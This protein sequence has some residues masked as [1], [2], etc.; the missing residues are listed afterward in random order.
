MFTLPSKLLYLVTF[1][2]LLLLAACNKDAGKPFEQQNADSRLVFTIAEQT[3]QPGSN[4]AKLK[5]SNGTGVARYGHEENR[6]HYFIEDG[7]FR[8]TTSIIRESSAA[9]Q[10]RAVL[11]NKEAARMSSSPNAPSSSLLGKNI[12]YRVVLYDRTSSPATF[13]STTLGTVGTPLY[14][15]V[16]KGK[17]YDWA[18]FSFNDETDPGDTHEIVTSG[19]RDLLYAKGTTGVIPGVS[20]DQQLYTVPVN[21]RLQHKL[22]NVSVQITAKNYPARIMGINASLGSGRYFYSNN[23]DLRTGEFVDEATAIEMNSAIRF[24]SASRDTTMLADYY[25]AQF[26]PISNFFITI[27]NLLIRTNSNVTKSLSSPVRYSW[28]NVS[29]TAGERIITKVNIQPVQ[30]ISSEKFKILFVGEVSSGVGNQD[31]SG[32]WQALNSSKNFGPNGTYPTTNLNWNITWRTTTANSFDDILTGNYKMIFAGNK[33]E[34][35]S[36]AV[37]LLATYVDRGGTVIWFTETS[38]FLNDRAVW[39]R[40]T[41]SQ[42]SVYSF[43]SFGAT[44]NQSPTLN[45]PFGDARGTTFG[46]DGL[47]G[48]AI[49]N[50]STT[51]VDVLATHGSNTAAAM[52]WKAKDRNFYYF[53]DGGMQR[54]NPQSGPNS[55]RDPFLLTAAPDCEPR[56]GPWYNRQ[57][58]S[59]SV[60]IMNIVAKTIDEVMAREK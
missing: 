5:A 49:G 10:N 38:S 43:N 53:G 18:V 8:V 4:L 27:N 56:I 50:L 16:D 39:S 3:G 44:F 48:Q 45:G 57:D 12:K 17:D 24:R 9:S 2:L 42:A 11:G 59:N 40:Y 26:A 34:T 60:V 47:F 41:G 19:S 35:S 36:E 14:V 28:D 32:I 25:T 46:D 1:L 23:I 7:A 21:V 15:N 37:N 29:P 30:D 6:Q 55:T 20:G 22:A 52:V 33:T 54:Y 58:V 13:V 31:I 51:R